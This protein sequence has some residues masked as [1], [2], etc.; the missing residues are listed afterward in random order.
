MLAMVPM[1]GTAEKLDHAVTRTMEEHYAHLSPS[2]VA[3]AFSSAGRC[4]RGG[5]VWSA[6]ILPLSWLHE[7]EPLKA[8]IKRCCLPE[9][10]SFWIR[11]RR[12]LRHCSDSSGCIFPAHGLYMR[13][14]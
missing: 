8:A 9:S 14:H 10:K 2:Y 5:S 1:R 13:Q 4:T 11:P 12:I 6:R 7:D 3:R